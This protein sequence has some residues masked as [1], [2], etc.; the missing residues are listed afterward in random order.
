ME[1][2]DGESLDTI[3]NSQRNLSLL[4]KTNYIVQVCRGLQYAHERNIIHRDIKP[5]NIMVLREGSTK[6]VDFGIARMGDDH[7]TRPGQVM[8]SIHYM[9]PEQISDRGVDTRTDLFA[10]GTVLYELLTYNLPFKGEDLRATLFKIIHDP[11]SP[12]SN[13]LKSYPSDL[14]A[15]I[16]R[17][18]AKDSRE[19]YQ[20]ADEL[21]FDLTQVQLQLKAGLVAELLEKANISIERGEL[22]DARVHLLELLKLDPQ[23]QSA[24]ER[25]RAL[26]KS[27]QER[28]R[29]EQVQQLRKEAEEAG[30]QQQFDKALR[31]IEHAITVDH[32]NP[33][34]VSIRDDLNRA[35][36]QADF[37]RDCMNRA[38]SARNSNDLDRALKYLEQ[39]LGRDPQHASALALRD[40]VFREIAHR[41]KQR[42][43]QG[44]MEKAHRQIASREFANALE[45]LDQVA[46]LDPNVSNLRGLV[47]LANEG[48]EQERRRQLQVLTFE[49]ERLLECN[50]YLAALAQIEN[51]LHIFPD[52]PILLRLKGIT[53]R[54]RELAEQRL[55]VNAQLA[56]SRN[57]LNSGKPEEALAALQSVSGLIDK[58]PLDLRSRYVDLEAAINESRKEASRLR[59]DPELTVPGAWNARQGVAGASLPSSS[60]ATT[61]EMGAGSSTPA[62]RPT[63]SNDKTLLELT[64]PEGQILPDQLRR[65][66]IGVDL[67]SSVGTPQQLPSEPPR[68]SAYG[69][70]SS[71]T[72]STGPAFENISGWR[73]DTLVRVEKQLATYLGPLARILVK[74]AASRT[75]NSEELYL[76]LAAH[77]ER[78]SDRNAFLAGKVERT[79]SRTRTQ[80]A[81][82]PSL[83]QTVVRPSQIELTQAEVDRAAHLLARHLG[84]IANVLAKR[85]AQRAGSSLRTLYSLLSEHLEN[86]TERA[87]FLRDSGVSDL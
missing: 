49:I 27:F 1:F 75:N 58:V 31:L 47:H 74:K 16:E 24:N 9:S 68:R 8:G 42:Q 71:E 80:P 37:V 13:Y 67:T 34:L 29:A 44:L 87:R 22:T 41:E 39:L 5:A 10:T 77:L 19:R 6:I 78:E 26:Q 53:E 86:N 43:V 69:P 51:G 57:L 28:R 72:N 59:A 46:E 56:A 18:L 11:P 17:A 79:Q 73:A 85:A 20:T 82:E 7:V 55:R 65:D 64:P 36:A 54:H 63:P 15:I 62:L 3:I 83:T 21:A 52:E 60:D 81:R 61:R 40:E 50:D 35:K 70:A 14:D 84:P 45:V 30:K 33:E 25:M 38:Q 2:L 48:I 4:E 12:L 66:V 32:T 23:N 76:L